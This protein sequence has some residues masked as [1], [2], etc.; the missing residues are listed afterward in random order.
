VKVLPFQEACSGF[1]VVTCA[2]KIFFQKPPAILKIVLKA[3]V[4]IYTGENLQMT[5]QENQDIK[6]LMRLL[7]QSLDL[8]CVF[9]ET[10]RNF[11]KFIFFTRQPKMSK[12]FAHL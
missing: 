8:V 4:D 5:V 3:G 9:K 12:T 7:E 1:Q 10:S 6:I 11:S 2:S